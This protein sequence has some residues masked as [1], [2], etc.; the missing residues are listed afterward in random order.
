ML[1]VIAL[2]TVIVS[3]LRSRSSS[4]ADKRDSALYYL[5]ERIG[6]IDRFLV[7]QTS[8]L[9][10]TRYKSQLVR[11]PVMLVFFLV[12]VRTGQIF[13]IL[14]LGNAPNRVWRLWHL[15]CIPALFP[16]RR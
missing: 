10:G 3:Y 2:G 7:Q 6:A 8:W 12:L 14:A 16:A 13:L 5:T 9:T 4:K 11:I 15:F 1:I